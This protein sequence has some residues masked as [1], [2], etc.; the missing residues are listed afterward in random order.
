M[1][2]RSGCGGALAIVVLAAVVLSI[3]LPP[4]WAGLVRLGLEATGL[5]ADEL[6]VR[7]EANPSLRL[8]VGQA[9]R[10]VVEGTMARWDGMTARSLD[11]T[12]DAVDLF[13]RRAGSVEGLLEEVSVEAGPA[14][15]LAVA[16]VEISGPGSGPTARLSV[17]PSEARRLVEALARGVGGVG[18]QVVLMA[19][20]RVALEVA[21]R[22]LLARV[23][24]VDGAVVVEGQGLPPLSVLA[25]GAMSGL[26][27]E[28]VAVGADGGL[29]IE[30]RLDPRRLGLGG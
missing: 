9:D 11:L 1:G 26:E 17:A 5:R 18:V 12:L 4:V 2:R 19:P 13:G 24:V 6:I 16:R 30:G 3:A 20:D 25:A 28:S 15:P 29:V 8:L 22:R 27:V 14:G 23:A 7:V 10:V 21:D